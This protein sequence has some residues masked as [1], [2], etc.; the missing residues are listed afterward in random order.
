MAAA[1]ALFD[2]LKHHGLAKPPEA[3]GCESQAV[4]LRPERASSAG[5]VD[6]P[7]EA[8]SRFGRLAH[9]LGQHQL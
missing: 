5:P 3:E 7:L 4:G 9:L 8:R 1:I 2:C 6:A